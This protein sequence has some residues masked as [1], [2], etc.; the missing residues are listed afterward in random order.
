MA[1]VGE[2]GRRA[3]RV[4]RRRD[5]G[6]AHGQ[7]VHRLHEPA[8]ALDELGLA[9]REVE[10]LTHGVGA[11]RRRAAAGEPHEARDG[12]RSVT[13]DRTADRGAHERA[14]AGVEPGEARPRRHA[15]GVHRHGRGPL[16]G[17]RD[18]AHGA[19]GHARGAQEPSRRVADQVPPLRRVLGRG[20]V[21][22]EVGR[23]RTVLDGDDVAGHA[24]Q[25]DLGTAGAQVDREDQLVAHGPG[26]AAWASIMSA[27]TARM[28]S[29]AS[30]LIPPATP[31]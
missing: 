28:N 6:E 10:H 7:V 1:V 21:V 11:R 22:A 15:V 5:A 19:R 31:P 17:D 18:R 13:R 16:A 29:S 14:A 30:A 3:R 9:V 25:P 8:G 27:I 2:P 23:H 20:P 26:T 4:G 24:D 12:P